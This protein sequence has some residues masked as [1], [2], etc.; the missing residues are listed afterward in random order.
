VCGGEA[1][2]ETDTMD[3]FMESSWYELRYASPKDGPDGWLD[4]GEV[5]YW[6]A[7]DQ[8]VGGAEHAT[9]HLIYARFFTKMLRDWGWVKGD[10]DEPFARLLTQGMVCKET[11]KCPEH[12]WLYPDE[13]TKDKTCA[14]C[15]KPVTVGRVEKMS[16]TLKNVVEPLPLIEKYGSDTVRVFSL[17]AAP[18][19]SVLEWSEAGVEGA[20]RFLNRVYRLVAAVLNRPDGGGEEPELRQKTHQTIKKVTEDVG[21]ERFHFNTAIAAIM[22][23]VN[24]A[25]QSPSFGKH[26]SPALREAAEATVRLL[27]PFAPH[28]A[29]EL[30]HRL[31][32]TTL[33]V[34]E[35]WPTFDPAIAQKKRVPYPVQ[36]NG[37]LRGQVEAEPE[38]AQANI[39]A[40]ARELAPVQAALDG[41]TI[42]KIV[43][44]PGR[45][46]NFVVR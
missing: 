30:W 15:G 2:R 8:Y 16:K 11:Y 18:P 39:E 37:K 13:V 29:E 46:I 43:F 27:S 34:Q 21:S 32:H 35:P 4:R 36:V 10:L 45:L 22:E 7:V 5:D 14:K 6:M 1:R 44:V 31:G 3:G 23:L 40:L 19:D 26:A 38:A 28:L 24:A 25:Y 41:K 33:L 20:W 12:D 17:F 42:A 9:K